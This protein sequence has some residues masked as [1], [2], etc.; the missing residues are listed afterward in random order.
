[1]IGCHITEIRPKFLYKQQKQ[2]TMTNLTLK[3]VLI[4]FCIEASLQNHP[5]KQC[6]P[7]LPPNYRRPLDVPQG[8]GWLLPQAVPGARSSRVAGEARS[9]QEA[10]IARKQRLP[11]G[12]SSQEAGA[13]MRQDEHGGRSRQEANDS[14]KGSLNFINPLE[15]E[16]VMPDNKGICSWL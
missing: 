9:C 6:Y 11:G 8:E 12:R 5:Q 4:S 1:M 15:K 13:A 10:G 14:Q 3:H 7:I 16:V 2:F